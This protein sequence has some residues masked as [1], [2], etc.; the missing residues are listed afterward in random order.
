MAWQIES[1]KIVRYHADV[2]DVLSGGCNLYKTWPLS[3][4]LSGSLVLLF[5]D[6]PSLVYLFH[7]LCVDLGEMPM[8]IPFLPCACAK[9]QSCIF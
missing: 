1:I 6:H 7:L 9:S 8:I 4:S 3:M 2:V 5:F